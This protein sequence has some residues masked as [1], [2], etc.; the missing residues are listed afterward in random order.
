VEAEVKNLVAGYVEAREF[1]CAKVMLW[2]RG[3][4]PEDG[5]SRILG[6]ECGVVAI[7]PRRKA[8]PSHPGEA[9]TKLLLTLRTGAWEGTATAAI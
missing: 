1:C 2:G 9:N 5:K 3:A 7:P 6:D 8:S 4:F